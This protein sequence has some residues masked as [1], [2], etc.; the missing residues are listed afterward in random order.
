MLRALQKALLEA[1]R[2][3]NGAVDG[4]GDAAAEAPSG[5]AELAELLAEH[6]LERLAET[7]EID[8]TDLRDAAALLTQADNVV[9]IWGE[10]LGW[11]ERG[12]GAL[13]ALATSRSC[14][15]WTRPR[16]RG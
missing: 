5:H 11:G 16:A 7:A 15:D 9:V 10:R 4:D 3:E 12:A 2:P 14:W 13:E 1:E 6:S 8:L